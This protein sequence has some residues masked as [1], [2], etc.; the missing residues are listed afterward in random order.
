MGIRP[1]SINTPRY[2]PPLT[3]FS[4]F[5]QQMGSS[6]SSEVQL[7]ALADFYFIFIYADDKVNSNKCKHTHIIACTHAHRR[8][9]SARP[10]CCSSL[11]SA[12]DWITQRWR[13]VGWGGL[14]GGGCL[15]LW[16][17]RLRVIWTRHISMHEWWLVSA[18][19]RAC[20]AYIS[21]SKWS[22]KWDLYWWYMNKVQYGGA[23]HVIRVLKI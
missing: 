6:G 14:G 12:L 16:L 15:T 19:Q 20:V 5:S 13:G 23:Y 17:S 8:L 7:W 22:Q 18:C 1:E 10:A 9:L 2:H 21:Y 4:F 3:P 11:L